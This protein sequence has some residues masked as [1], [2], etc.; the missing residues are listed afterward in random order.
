MSAESWSNS[1][2]C[3]GL[4]SAPV[5]RSFDKETGATRVVAVIFFSPY[6]SKGNTLRIRGI[7]GIQSGGLLWSSCKNEFKEPEKFAHLCAGDDEGRQQA[8]GKIVSAIDQQTAPH[9]FADERRAFDGEFDPDH[10]AFATDFPDKAEFGGELRETL[11]QFGAA[12]ADIFE[13]LSVLDDVQ[14]LEGHGASQRAAAKRGAVHPGRDTRSNILR[15]ENGA[16]RKAGSE[17]LGDQDDVRLRG[18]LLI[19]EEAAGAAKPALN[20]I[21]DQESAVQRGK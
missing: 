16:E 12:Q 21:G 2:V 3:A 13:E 8:Q 19:A 4:H 11:M 10:Q 1:R 15:S 14:E 18:K 20:L 6:R 9:G 5:R 17:R 7:A